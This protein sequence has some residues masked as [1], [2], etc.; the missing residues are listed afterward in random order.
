MNKL[1]LM[2]V[3]VLACLPAA[4]GAGVIYKYDD[5]SAEGYGGAGGAYLAW[6]VRF[7]VQAGGDKI[8]AVEI[9]LHEAGPFEAVV[10]EDIGDHG[11]PADA[12]V[13]S[14]TPFTGVVGWNAIP[15]TPVT[16]S[17]SFFVGAYSTNAVYP[18][19]ADAEGYALHRSWMSADPA[20]LDLNDLTN[21][22]IA[23]WFEDVGPASVAMVRAQATPEPA[24]IAL[25]AA[26][27]AAALLLR[28][29]RK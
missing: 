22:I 27:G 29:R 24:T 21:A 1:M 12:R 4:A 11:N 13:R 2:A 7:T 23:N 18:I 6:M 10:W 9:S 3:T 19:N 16:V 17:G 14:R 20:G 26:G 25:L 15:I 8:N 5:G 28:R